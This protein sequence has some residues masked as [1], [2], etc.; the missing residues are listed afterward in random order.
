MNAEMSLR[1]QNTTF[2]STHVA[3]CEMLQGLGADHSLYPV[4]EPVEERPTNRLKPPA[5]LQSFSQT[6]MIE[7]STQQPQGS[8]V[9]KLSKGREDSA[10]SDKLR[11]LYFQ[12][13][14]ETVTAFTGR[15]LYQN[16]LSCY[17][18]GGISQRTNGV[19]PSTLPVSYQQ[20]VLHRGMST[21]IEA[22]ARQESELRKLAAA[23]RAN[24]NLFTEPHPQIKTNSMA[25]QVSLQ[26]WAGAC[27]Y[28]NWFVKGTVPSLDGSGNSVVHHKK[29]K[30][31]PSSR[32]AQASIADPTAAFTPGP[33]KQLVVPSDVEAQLL[34]YWKL[35]EEAAAKS[36]L[37]A[38]RSR[39]AEAFAEH[40][41]L[42][43]VSSLLD[44]MERTEGFMRRIGMRL[45]SQAT[46]APH[47]HA[48]LRDKEC[49]TGPSKT[50]TP[51]GRRSESDYARFRAYVASTKDEFKLMHR[52]D[53][54][55]P[56]QP[57][58]LQATLL[59]HQ[60]D[61]LRFLVSLHA[62]H[63]HGILADE[64]GVGKTVQTLAFLLHLKE[65]RASAAVAA[66]GHRGTGAQVQ[67]PRP[68]L[69]LAPL[70]VI[71]EWREACEQF[72]SP[73]FRVGLFQALDDPA[74]DALAYDLILMPVHAV[75]SMGT[76]AARVQWGYIVVDEAHK[77]VANLKT[78]T[79]QAILALPCERRLVLTGTPL[80]SDLQELWSL[81]HFLNPNVFSDNDAFEEVFRRP[82]QVYE[83][84]EMELTEEERGLLVLRLHQ[85]LRPFLLR[86]TKADIDTSLRMTF[87][88]V[89]CPLSSVQQRV[90]RMLRQQGR[91]PAVLQLRENSEETDEDTDS[92]AADHHS[93]EGL[94][95][96]ACGGEQ[97]AGK[98]RHQCMIVMDELTN[99]VTER[100]PGLAAANISESV[101]KGIQEDKSLGLCSAN[102]SESAAQQ[103]CNHAFTLPFF[104][105]V[106]Q[107]HG[108]DELTLE[109]AP[110]A[111]GGKGAAAM[112]LACSG[113][114]LFLHLLLS[115]LFVARRKVVLFTHWLSCVD[116]MVDYLHSRG[117]HH[118]T[119]VLTGGS[120][121]T[122]R[123]AS[124]RRFREDPTCLFFVLSMKA[125]GCGI[126]LQVAHMVVLLDRDYTT[127]NED[128]ALARVYRIGQR[129][130]VHALYF[131]T[132][133]VSE[134]RVTRRAEEKDRPRR[135]IIDDGVYQVTEPV[136]AEAVENDNDISP[137]SEDT[138][139]NTQ[140]E[141]HTEHL[142]G[143]TSLLRSS[144][145]NVARA[146]RQ[147][148]EGKPFANVTS[149]S[150]TREFWA[151]LRQLVSS[152]D[153]L[154]PTDED[155][156]ENTSL[157]ST[158]AAENV[159]STT[160][161]PTLGV[162][163]SAMS[164]LR[165][166][167]PPESVEALEDQ[168]QLGG[169][170]QHNAWQAESPLSQSSTGS[171]AAFAQHDEHDYG[172]SCKDNTNARL[173][174][175]SDDESGARCTSAS[176]VS[177]T[178]KTCETPTDPQRYPAMFWLEFAYLLCIACEGPAIPSAALDTAE[179]ND[180]K[181]D[182]PAEQQRRRRRRDRRAAKRMRLA[183]V[184]VSD[185][186]REKC[187]KDGLEDEMEIAARFLEHLDARAHRRKTLP[188]DHSM[189][190]LPNGIQ[191][192]Q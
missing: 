125:G 174:Q 117:W 191:E 122:E 135:A 173:T 20:S 57:R 60:M 9:R 165:S 39:D 94:L 73:S 74:R 71:R 33:S 119:E 126:N 118:H 183:T 44:I 7:Q 49:E 179:R 96:A 12:V 130:T 145:I 107:R 171:A 142:W 92:D 139:G 30:R 113:K 176:L 192:C 46:V 43:K 112:A 42:L 2:V 63:I 137:A 54:F 66:D 186:F 170:I 6:R 34:K 56:S 45:E 103:L 141:I 163:T 75:R 55:V 101:R 51:A 144:G 157:A 72:V 146:A 106:L 11:S 116:L 104:S 161:P 188:S 70:S 181:V 114:F 28:N 22:V 160:C 17:D 154:V 68:H 91:T 177:V 36:R 3:F 149:P 143:I 87:H 26:Q 77:A 185:T 95:E 97:P 50:S 127:T 48:A 129:H 99:L 131:S 124:V 76:V 18:G 128:Q 29:G 19:A 184:E 38:L 189:K 84:R 47:P 65:T 136:A 83:A 85:V 90:L 102:A 53:A 1:C 82:F 31:G 15:Q 147:S 100:L 27:R 37:N 40:I 5:P 111:D 140:H 86:R 182:G 159:S 175:L 4:S 58:A 152:L 16:L 35:H 166:T 23:S 59:P 67:A 132:D 168:M 13:V 24:L 14:K 123:K 115:R 180:E 64:M 69:V 187:W 52:I 153:D 78:F 110:D 156:E 134:H 108:L 88:R 158:D 62:N 98:P 81:L 79:A 93:A 105:Q 120:S 25:P 151:A 8:Q 162:G 178:P 190:R 121:E 150:T 155:R 80:S 61:G 21:F 89:L 169:T 133:D 167:F 148:G 109:G 32:A 10:E 41:S 172:G 164:R 138:N